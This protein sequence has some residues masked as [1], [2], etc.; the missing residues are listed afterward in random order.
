[1][2][3]L[4][5]NT[6]HLGS[7]ADSKENK[8]VR[9]IVKEELQLLTPALTNSP[10]IALKG[11]AEKTIDKAVHLYSE[12]TAKTLSYVADLLRGFASYYLEKVMKCQWG[13]RRDTTKTQK[14][15][16][17]M[18]REQASETVISEVEM[19]MHTDTFLIDDANSSRSLLCSTK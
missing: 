14:V 2:P 5:C 9:A 19:K 8:V 16:D 12:T 11:S 17:D 6:Q 7:L 18:I 1:M 4:F 10:K 3:L 15:L 13:S